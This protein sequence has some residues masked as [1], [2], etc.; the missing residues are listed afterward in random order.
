[1]SNDTTTAQEHFGM[2]VTALVVGF[3]ML[4]IICG[5]IAMY[6]GNMA[7]EKGHPNGGVIAF[8]GLVETV[9]T[10]I[11]LVSIFAK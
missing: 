8:L 10:G 9:L 11:L 3:F 2:G 4:G 6:Q 5:P 7:A 1:M